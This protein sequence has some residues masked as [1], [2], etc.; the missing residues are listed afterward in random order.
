MKVMATIPKTNDPRFVEFY[1][2][3][4]DAPVRPAG[5]LGAADYVDHLS[6]LEVTVDPQPGCDLGYCWFNCLDQKF[7]KG[8]Q[9]IY[10]WSLWL[11]Q[12]RFIAQHHAILQ[13]EEG[14][15]VDP[16]PNEGKTQIILFVPDNRAPFDIDEL[17]TPPNLEWRERAS[18]IWVA[19]PK[20]SHSFF[21][22]RM[23][24]EDNQLER[25]NRA[26]QQFAEMHP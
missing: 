23:E 17:R 14:G 1:K 15:Y 8:G 4:R 7:S 2:F 20:R 16:T 21:I 10:G 13:F 3:L 11:F 25:I 19:G 24:P 26:R 22:A 18:Y 12:D 5:G 6:I 9:V